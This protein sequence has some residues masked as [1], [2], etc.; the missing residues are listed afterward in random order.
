[1][2]FDLAKFLGSKKPVQAPQPQIAMAGNRPRSNAVT[3]RPQFAQPEAAPMTPAQ[4]EAAIRQE[5]SMKHTTEQMIVLE[6]VMKQ[7]IP[8]LD[9]QSK[10]AR[11]D[12][13]LQLVKCTLVQCAQL[14]SRIWQEVHMTAPD[15]MTEART[16]ARDEMMRN[17]VRQV[18]GM[19]NAVNTAAKQI[20]TNDRQEY[21]KALKNWGAAGYFDRKLRHALGLG[22]RPV[23]PPKFGS[24]HGL[25][26][27]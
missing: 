6:Q 4:H 25:Y 8:K 12:R 5:V 14:R 15:D 19:A 24:R 26:G 21:A 18:Y 22:S 13:K 10:M 2:P 16:N 23:T 20:E 11:D 1:M 17:V 9:S 7:A 3:A 27:L